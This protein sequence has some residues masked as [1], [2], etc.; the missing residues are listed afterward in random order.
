MAISN[1]FIKSDIESYK[2]YSK[3][4]ADLIVDKR[5]T[6]ELESLYGVMYT[7]VDV[8]KS[9]ECID[10]RVPIKEYLSKIKSSVI[11]AF[12]LL[13]ENYLQASGLQLRSGIEAFFRSILLVERHYVYLNNVRQRIFGVTEELRT[14]KSKATAQKI[15]RLTVFVV[16]HYTQTSVVKSL[17]ELNDMY[18]IFSGYSHNDLNTGISPRSFLVDYSTINY[19]ETDNFIE[20]FKKVLINFLVILY[21][22]D[23]KYQN[24]T[25]DRH[26]RQYIETKDKEFTSKIDAVD[27]ELIKV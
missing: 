24:E 23:V 10:N 25:F 15:G 13:N 17:E 9:Y 27:Q 20:D 1:E 12:D 14:L 6:T 8:L 21:Y 7:L 19:D 4:K 2:E 22:F 18:S 5:Y 11:I 16:N 3:S 26:S